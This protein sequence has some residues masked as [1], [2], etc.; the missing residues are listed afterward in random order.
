MRNA[1]LILFVVLLALVG[2]GWLLFQGDSG[3]LTPVAVVGPGEAAP[4]L[5]E[6][7]G[8]APVLSGDQ[9]QEASHRVEVEAGAMSL[10]PSGSSP[11]ASFETGP[12][13]RGRVIDTLGNPLA[14]AMVVVAGGDPMPIDFAGDSDSSFAKRW[15]TVSASDGTFLVQG[16]EPGGLRM[17]VWLAGFAPLERTN[18][19]LPAGSGADFGDQIL[20]QGV[21]LE[22]RVV[23]DGGGAVAGAELVAQPVG[24]D[25]PFAF[26]TASTDRQP[27]AVSDADGRFRIDMLSAGPWKLSVKSA[28]HPDKTF[29]GR[30]ERPGDRRLGLELVLDAGASISGKVAGIPSGAQAGELD[31]LVV[32]ATPKGQGRSFGP[33]RAWRE[34][35]VAADGT[36]VVEGCVKEADYEVQA[37]ITDDRAAMPWGGEVKTRTGVIA[38]RGGQGGLVLQWTGTTGVRLAVADATGAPIEEFTVSYGR[39]MLQPLAIDGETVRHHPAGKATLEELN[40]G[41]WGGAFKVLVDA[42]GY[43]NIVREVELETGRVVDAGLFTLK[44][45]PVLTVRVTDGETGAPIAGAD[46]RLSVLDAEASGFGRGGMRGFAPSDAAQKSRSGRT[47]ADGV[48]RL[49]T[50]PGETGTLVVEHEGHT[51]FSDSDLTMPLGQTLTREVSLG[52]GGRV[53]VLVLDS[54]GNPKPGAQVERRLV[55]DETASRGRRG[56]AIFGGTPEGIADQ[57]GV[58]LF[59]HLEPGE[60]E[61]R[62]GSAP[63]SGGMMIFMG[64]TGQQDEEP[65]TAATVTEGSLSRIELREKP[66]GSVVGLVREAGE[67]LAGA[68]LRLTK[69]TDDNQL[70]GFG[71]FAMMGGSGAN[72]AT[73]DGRG[74]YVLTGVEPGSYT[75]SVRHATREMESTIDVEVMAGE[76]RV[77]LDL[78]VAIIEG[79]VT[80]GNGAPLAGVKVEVQAPGQPNFGR[81]IFGGMEGQA[82]ISV[83]GEEADPSPTDANGRYR[84][85]GVQANTD[86]QVS[87]SQPGAS[88]ATSE[89]FQVADGQLKSGVDLVLQPAG[90]IHV[91]VNGLSESVFG[92]LNATYLDDEGV[93]PVTQFA[94]EGEGTLEGLRPGMWSVGLQFA[95][96]EG[97]QEAPDPQDIEVLSGE[98]SEVSFDA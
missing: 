48:A 4:R 34:G 12:G 14:G 11:K 75:L 21:L 26:F 57:T 9:D 40:T 53:E 91:V 54:N 5:A 96:P 59:E 52:V 65:W 24:D 74:A 88:P 28:A 35:V 55:G 60:H 76:N 37:R 86:L 7:A 56:R 71:G 84:L 67:A 61:F 89:T 46:V 42:P 1:P 51:R 79:R 83:G 78:P 2:G 32:R 73:A 85:R 13:V 29:E 94:A 10:T 93:E 95:G 66:Q 77:D 27:L 92:I 18:L 8:T 3:S 20:D 39:G 45:A 80:D 22:G 30:T 33:M 58:S 64:T 50:F 69:R 6:S 38:A 81:L 62:L 49:S 43:Q 36:F 23:V 44:A 41:G 31:G 87:A 90:K 98:T 97:Q 68:K 25:N 82:A 72:S 16:P 70:D 63:A 15:R 47:D 19:V 17:G